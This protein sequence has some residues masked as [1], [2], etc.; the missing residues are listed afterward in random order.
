MIEYR[1]NRVFGTWHEPD[2]ALTINNIRLYEYQIRI[3]GVIQDINS[4]Y[5]VELL[6]Q[7]RMW[8]QLQK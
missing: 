6:E 8:E 1:R 5:F 2:T 3:N 4:N 7:E